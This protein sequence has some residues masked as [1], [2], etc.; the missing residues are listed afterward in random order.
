MFSDLLWYGRFF[1]YLL[2]M[3]FCVR[4]LFFISCVGLW[5]M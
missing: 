3:L 4:L 1:R 5:F 2:S